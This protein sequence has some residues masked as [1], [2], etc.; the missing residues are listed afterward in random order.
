MLLLHRLCFCMSSMLGRL[1]HF[2]GWERTVSVHV[3]IFNFIPSVH[4]IVSNSNGDLA[5]S[6]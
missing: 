3:L 6:S 1:E 2:G 4:L 5:M